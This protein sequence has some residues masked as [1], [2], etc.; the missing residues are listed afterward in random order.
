M[1]VSAPPRSGHRTGSP[2]TGDRL[3]ARELEILRL[4]DAGHSNRDI[5]EALGISY[6]TATT[7]VTNIFNKLGA[8]SRTAAL[9]V[10]RRQGLL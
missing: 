5:G 7:H 9:A 8:S 4:I 2:D 10:A 1:A 6:R 3:S